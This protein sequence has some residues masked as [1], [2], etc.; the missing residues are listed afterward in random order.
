MPIVFV[1]GVNT[2]KGAS[3]DA[4][5]RTTE[6][7]LQKHLT[8]IMIGG[9]LLDTIPSVSFP[10]WGDLGC[11]FAWDMDSLPR[12]DMQSLG[13]GT[14][15][16]LQPLFAHVRDAFSTLP[17]QQ[18]LT[19]LAK[20]RLSLAIDV[21]NDL[22][23]QAVTKGEEEA[24]AEF[25]VQASSY[26]DENPHPAW[27][28]AISTDEQLLSTL[29]SN[30]TS[31][32]NVQALGGFGTVY[33]KLRLAAAKFKQ[34]VQSM[35]GKA[36]DEA[37]DFLSTKLLAATRDSL[38]A[39]LGR[40]FGD[41]FVYLDHRGDAAQPGPIPTQILNA[42]DSAHASATDEPFVIIGHSLGGVITFDLLSHFRPD[43]EV[44][45][46]V[47]VGSQVAH[48]EELKLYRASDVAIARPERAKTPKNI[49]R[50][51]NIYDEVDIFSYSVAR[52]FDRVDVDAR[53]DTETYTIKAHGA[54]FEQ[55]RFYKRIRSRIDQLP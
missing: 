39:V 5:T 48:F 51:I 49:K 18:P 41:V 11:K 40:F 22:A 13:G 2:R 43:I 45:L 55:E 19:T 26:A 53:Y 8:G 25:V 50:W 36:V 33:N 7:F 30:L 28:D 38:N 31:Q 20:K 14:D 37:G 4:G 32:S 1:H 15:V 35:A 27:L 34:G 9:K 6:K 10:Y 52:I 3:Y 21:I 24:V 23:L 12:S 54:Y 42:L 44:D 16:A 17:R 46:F 47:S 29:Y